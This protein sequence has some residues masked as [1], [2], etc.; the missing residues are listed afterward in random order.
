MGEMRE[1][2][3]K[4]KVA[5]YLFHNNSYHLSYHAAF[6]LHFCVVPVRVTRS[7]KLCKCNYLMAHTRFW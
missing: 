4:C 3:I 1:A 5:A 7:K 2:V 6:H